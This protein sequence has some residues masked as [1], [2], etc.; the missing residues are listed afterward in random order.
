ML[1]FKFDRLALTF[2]ASGV[3]G[4]CL[5]ELSLKLFLIVVIPLEEVLFIVRGNRC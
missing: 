4:I 2:Y 1:V 3:G 5:V